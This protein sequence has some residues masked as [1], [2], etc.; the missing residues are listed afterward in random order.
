MRVA[1][2]YYT[3]FGHTRALAEQ[4]ALELGA[5]LREIRGVRAHSYPVMGF[6]AIFNAHFRIHPMDLDFSA[7]DVVVLCTP[8][9]AGRPACPTRTFLRDAR[10]EGKRLVIALSTWSD[11]LGQSL[12]HIERELAG[13]LATVVYTTHTVTKPLVSEALLREAGQ[14]LAHRIDSELERLSRSAPT[15]SLAPE[16]QPEPEAE[17][18]PLH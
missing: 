1:V 8:I 15:V 7:F 2:V 6:G 18:A 17:H 13:K 10:L 4:L 5:E 12:Q 11:D 14:A 9:W 3:R 16:A